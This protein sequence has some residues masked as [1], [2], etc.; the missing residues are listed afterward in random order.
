MKSNPLAVV[1][2]YGDTLHLRNVLK[3]IRSL[4]IDSVVINDGNGPYL[5]RALK[6]EG[7]DVFDLKINRG[8]GTATQKGL[9]IAA[10]RG[11]SGIIS[12]DADDA[13]NKVSIASVLRTAKQAPHAP[14]LT[15]RF[16]HVGELYIPPSKIAP[17]AFASALFKYATGYHL[18]DVSSGLCYY[19]TSLSNIPWEYN[20]FDFMVIIYLTQYGVL[21][22]SS[23]VRLLVYF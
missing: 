4:F 15:C 5:T 20:R 19:P 18:T 13:H 21:T 6:Q 3:M 23:R 22:I 7:Y 2:V 1:P 16:K 17:N 12:V 14:V 9:Q 8:V 11:Y 10:E